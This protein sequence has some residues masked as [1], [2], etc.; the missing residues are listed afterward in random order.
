MKRY[1]IEI[2]PT[3]ENDLTQRYQQ[4]AKES[5]EN[6]VAWYI[7]IIEGIE[8]LDRLAL[9]CPIAPED[10]D[11]QRGVRHLI[12][13]SYRILYLVEDET[14]KVLHIRHSRHARKL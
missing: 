4:I 6:A 9:R 11:I 14:V 8:A 2:K 3:A 10:I 7:T 1:R 13:G 5:P 12:I